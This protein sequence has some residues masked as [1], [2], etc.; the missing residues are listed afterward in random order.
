MVF[1][2]KVENFFNWS[3]YLPDIM[4]EGNPL[5]HSY[6]HDSGAYFEQAESGHMFHTEFRIMHCNIG[7]SLVY[8][9]Y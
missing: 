5:P 9:L 4:K 1:V 6:W 3:R 7:A 2:W 8:S